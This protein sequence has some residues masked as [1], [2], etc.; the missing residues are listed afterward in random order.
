MFLKEKRDGTIKGRACADGRNQRE[1]AVPG[2][3]TSLTVSL[4]AVLIIATID[5]YEERGVNS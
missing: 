3:T 4:E 5:A 1:T 2:V